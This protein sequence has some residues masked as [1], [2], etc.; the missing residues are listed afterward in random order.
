[1]IYLSPNPNFVKRFDLTEGKFKI[2]SLSE[3]RYSGNRFAFVK[4]TFIDECL[5]IEAD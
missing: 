1:M 4:L 5:S 2:D 3:L